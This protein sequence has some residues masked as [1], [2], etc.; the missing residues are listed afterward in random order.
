MT[1]EEPKKSWMPLIVA[2][3]GFV[4]VTGLL[5]IGIQV[6]GLENIRGFIER[7]GPFAPLA[8]IAIK[9]AT[10][11]FAP[12]TSGPIQLSAGVMFGLWAGTLYTLI[13]EVIGGSISFWIARRFGRDVVRRFVREDGLMRVDDFVNQIVDWKTLIY[14]RLFLFSI[15]DFIS[16]A[17]G[18][19]RL[20]YRTYFLVSVFIGVIPTFVAVALGT[21]LTEERSELVM[22]Y[23]LIAVVSALPLIFQKRIRKWLKMDNH[24]EGET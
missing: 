2:G 11:V 8:Y 22:L 13:G 18:L 20:R 6:I 14:A 9:A 4:A 15:F 7:A 12:L 19:A 16:Y 21:S 24:A 17:V 5:I 10:Y 23:V 3:I 1:Q